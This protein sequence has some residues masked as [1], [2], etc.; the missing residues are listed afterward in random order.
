MIKNRFFNILSISLAILF[1]ISIGEVDAQ[2]KKISLP[3]KLIQVHV[4]VFDQPDL[5]V[6]NVYY[7]FLDPDKLKQREYYYCKII[8]TNNE[9]LHIEVDR[10]NNSSRL[11]LEYAVNKDTVLSAK[12]FNELTIYKVN[13]AT[14][15]IY[16]TY[17]KNAYI[18]PSDTNL[19]SLCTIEQADI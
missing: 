12:S 17:S 2:I 16:S 6:S 4:L 7:M 1:F 11:S 3:K 10:G 18:S 13:S 5:K 9:Q 15:R 19:T 8:T 14:Y